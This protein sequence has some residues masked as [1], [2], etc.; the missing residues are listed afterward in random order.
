MTL[1]AIVA[2]GMF[3]WGLALL[4]RPSGGGE[5]RCRGWLSLVIPCPVCAAV[6]LFTTGFLVSLFPDESLRVS[7]GTY[8]LF[9][10]VMLITFVTLS[11]TSRFGH[12]SSEQGLAFG[13]LFTA[14]YFALSVFLVPHFSDVDK[15][16]RLAVFHSSRGSV[17]PGKLAGLLI[18]AILAVSAGF[19]VQRLRQRSVR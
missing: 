1:H 7:V 2:L 19:L 11:A 12:L 17:D 9:A 6:I 14:S 18:A 15:V 13:M 4:R 16:Y 8:A 10:A 3:F 5:R